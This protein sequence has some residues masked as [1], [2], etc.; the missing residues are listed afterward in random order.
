MASI[1]PTTTKT[2]Q[3]RYVVHYRDP[4]GRSREKW[5][6]RKVDAQR[7]ADGV[8]TDKARGEYIDSNA[9][10]IPLGDMA[11][12]WLAG[13]AD[14]ALATRKQEQS[15]L[16]SMILPTF[17]HRPIKSITHSEIQI[18][19]ASLDHAPNTKAKAL[20]KLRSILALARHDRLISHNPA[21]E[22]KPP[23]QVPLRPGV[24][25]TDDQINSVLAAAEAVDERTA[26]V[27]HLMARCGLR[28]S[29][30]LALRRSDVNLDEG[31]VDVRTSMPR[32]GSPTPVKGRH[33]EEGGRAF[34]IPNDV[35][36]RL[37]RHLGERQVA[38]IN[39]LVVTA[40]R[41]GPLRYP[42]WRSRIWVR[43]VDRL[44]FDLT[45][46]DL[47]KTAAT[48]LV[49]ID[50]WSS[51][52]IQAFLGHLDPAISQKIYTLITA[53]DLPRPSTLNTRSS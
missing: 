27:V 10:R 51:S 33:N 40:P 9:G 31:T 50:R 23:E 29:E 15:Y 34:R 26:V 5:Y 44:D 17:A 4:N 28:A 41:G 16:N 24:A 12:R 43:I 6:K 45:S 14:K 22:A 19:L 46:H 13:R 20:Q 48:R 37:R 52:E 53:E 1:E 49:K 21:V 36:Q 47:R 8:E 2:G 38:S 35:V 42:N 39:D 25:L 11:D 18:W 30:A 32:Q 3:R 7:F